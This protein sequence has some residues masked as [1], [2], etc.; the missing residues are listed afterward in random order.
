MVDCFFIGCARFC[1]DT[2]GSM[3]LRRNAFVYA[4]VAVCKQ[5]ACLRDGEGVMD[6]WNASP[7][8]N[9]QHAFF[10][11]GFE[12]CMKLTCFGRHV[13]KSNIIS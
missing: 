10:G 8:D 7:L 3:F 12:R 4:C 1:R 5:R 13:E 9:W 2:H 11:C 6:R